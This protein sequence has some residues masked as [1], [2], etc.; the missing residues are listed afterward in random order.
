MAIKNKIF[1][2]PKK[3]KILNKM[4]NKKAVFFTIDSLLASGIV[5]TAILLISNFY[6][7]E[8]KRENINYASQDL[9]RVFSTMR[10]G[11]IDNDY[12]KSLISSG[13]ITNINNTILEQI[14]DFWADGKIERAGNLTKNLTESVIPS[15]YGFSILVNDEEIYSRSLPVKR[16]LVSSRKIISGIA[17]AK[18]TEGFTS[19]VLLNGIRSKKTNAYAYFGGY[20]GD[21]N[22]TKK[23]I[24]PNDAAAFNNS[25]LEVEAGGDFALYINGAFSGN[26]VKGSAGGGDMLADK[27]NI[28]SLYLPN[29]K[30]G[31]NTI[32]INFTS[33]NSY[34]AGGFL[35]VAY[36]TSSYNDTQTLG[37][38][39]Y[40]FPG[41]DG[42][43]NF[44]SSIYAPN[45][46]GYMNASLHF[47]SQYQIYFTI[48]NTTIFESSPSSS[49]QVVTLNNSNISNA[50]NYGFLGQKTIPI[51]L[52]IKNASVVLETGGKTDSA[53]ITDRTSSMSSCDVS[54]NC[55]AGLCDSNPS[56]GC[57]DRRDN[58]AVKADDKFIDTTLKS[59]D[60]NVALV[61]FGNDA[62]PVC[63]FHDFSNNNAS[64]K[65]RTDSYYNEW[66]GYTCI[67][68]GIAGATELLTENEAL[69]GLNHLSAINTTQFHVGDS[70]SG[71]SVTIKFNISANKSKFIKSRL[72][73]FGK[74]VNTDSGYM[75]CVYF[76]GN[77]AGRMCEPKQSPGWHTCSYPLK[78]EWFV[79]NVSNVTITGG[80]TSGCFNT[81]GNNDEWDFKDVKL[82]VWESQNSSPSAVYDDSNLNEVQI[83]DPPLS[84]MKTLSL[85]INT[86]KSKMKS[87]N[88]KF[89]AIGID[90]S[91]YDCVFINGNYIGSVDY[92]EWNGTNV[93][94]KV[95]FD[96]PTAWLNS[97]LNEVNI[98]S[99]TTSGCHKTSGN[100]NEWR[101]RN[102]N[103]TATY[104]E[105]PSAYDRT[106]SMLVM[107]DGE[108]N[109]KIGDCAGCDSA[110]ARAETVQ[111]ACDAHNL[112]GISIYAVAFGNVGQTAINN[113]NQTACC[114]DCSHFYTSNSSDELIE[115][116]AK[117]AQSVG[118]ISYQSQ[119]VNISSGNLGRTRLYPDSYL[120][121]NYTP[122][123][124]QF[125]KIPLG[126]ETERFGN[127]ISSGTLDIYPNTSISEAKVTSYSGNKWTDNL[128]VNG[129]TV[130]RLSDYGNNYQILGDPFA[131]NIPVDNINQG[132]NSITIST[133]INSTTSTGGSN[134]SRVIYTL[135]L[136]SFADYSSVVAKSDG[137][138]WT[139]SFE[140][141]TAATIKVPPNYNGA[142]LCSF[143]SKTYDT[144]DALDNAVFKLFSNLD[145]DKDGKLEVNID[146]SNLEV[147]TLTISKVPSLWGP[148]II[149]VRVWE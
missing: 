128:V 73:I 104:T 23:L 100:N 148:A 18:P 69:Y 80:T 124:A 120:A 149:E 64:L 143:A 67:S 16:A 130:Y 61:G 85:N 121:F 139:V 79:E 13:E 98:T 81:A 6:F 42:I 97:G 60:N 95:L 35:R 63:D 25:Y 50:L 14:G 68:C 91:Y 10:I 132:S 9:A 135:L 7:A 26:Y 77:Y 4:V 129:N 127:N 72:T 59:K 146:S 78:P 66:C 48:G 82:A 38:E 3:S 113:L 136:N 86:D 12:A 65:N 1:D 34:I 102:L 138:S 17:K 108:A 87:A 43:I 101:F 137:C 2:F 11:D 140:E 142:D 114:D 15:R 62:A 41:I 32:T 39:K 89:E 112:Y 24:L 115:I 8:Q 93:W 40:L 118:N 125:N 126:F 119:S 74:N 49:E 134:D 96:V 75:D 70:G 111:K 19:R 122:L 36:V 133:G 20:E 37:S 131:V 141:G 28:S 106:K 71:T 56:G 54:V 31:E 116:Y 109:T 51:R 45:E 30:A 144:N 33:G 83:G 76:N 27:W 84:E 58:V 21:G 117:I 55:T 46:P 145:I 52:G 110:G 90:P 88:L 107:S 44:Y 147:N 53:L 103:L 105:E 94:Q 92:Q 22:L 57:H 5:I 47:L 123:E 29:F 99:G